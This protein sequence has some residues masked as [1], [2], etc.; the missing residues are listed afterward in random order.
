MLRA[1]IVNASNLPNIESLGKSD[2]YV[3]TVFQGVKQKTS[4]KKGDLNPE[5]DEKLEWELT[6]KPPSPD[7]KLELLVK[8][9]DTV[10]R[11]RL[12][13]K[14][15]ILLRNLMSSGQNSQEL[16]LPLVDGSDQPT[17]GVLRVRMEYTAPRTPQPAPA[18]SK[19]AANV[20][21][22]GGTKALNSYEAVQTTSSG[23][24]LL[25]QG[26][27]YSAALEGLGVGP[28]S[29][30]LL[31]NKETK[32]Q[33]RVKVVE[34]RGLIGGDL[35]PTC[36]V[37]LGNDGKSTRVQK[38]TSNPWFDEIFFYYLKK[39]PSE[40]WDTTLEFRVCNSRMLRSKV[41]L[42]VF[43]LDLGA[44]YDQPLHAFV[45]KWL[46]LT[47]LDEDSSGVMGFLKVSIA[48]MGPNDECPDLKV[49]GNTG[50]EDVESNLLFPAG[51]RLSPA[52]FELNVFQAEDLPRMDTGAMSTVKR[53]LGFGETSSK[54][55]V[56]PFL[57]FSFA[58]K[59]V[60]TTVVYKSD[61]PEFKQRLY[62]G[63]QFPAFANQLKL[64][65][66]DWDRVGDS[67]SIGTAYL[68]LAS[69]SAAGED[70]FLPTF[71]PCFVNFYGST[72]EFSVFGK[73][74]Q[75]MLDEGEGEGCAYRGRCLV[76]LRTSVG[77]YPNVASE[78]LDFEEGLK[79]D[80]YLRRR[81][82]L[83][84]CAF[85]DATMVSEVDKPVEFEVSMGNFGNK[86][87]D[88]VMP[89]PSF[90]QPTNAVFDGCQY[91]FLPWKGAK[92]CVTVHCQWE[93]ISHRLH[94]LNMLLMTAR[95]LE[96]SL[97][98]LRTSIQAGKTQEQLAIEFVGV[99]D[100]LLRNCRIP[101][102]TPELH[103][104]STNLLDNLL[105]G[106]R[107]ARLDS[108]IKGVLELKETATDLEE[109]AEQLDMY[110]ATLRD[111]A[112]EPQNSMP[113]I[114]I[115]ML[116]G[117]K[118]LAYCRIPAH[119]ILFAGDERQSGADCGRLQTIQLKF[120]GTKN[121]SCRIPALL[122]VRLWLGKEQE[123]KAW[124][125][126]HRDAETVVYAETY[127][128]QASVAGHWVTKGP[129][130]TRPKWSDAGGDM[131]LPRENFG[132]PDG[133]RFAG[134]WFVDPEPSLFYEADAGR[135]TFL[136]DVFENENRLPAGG[137]MPALTQWSDVRGDPSQ[138][139]DEIAAP[140][141]WEWND[142]WTVDLNRAVDEEGWEYCVEATLGGYGP[143]DKLYHL[144]RRRR[145][146]RPRTL[147]H[148]VAAED[149]VADKE[150]WEYAPLFGMKFHARERKVDMVRRRRWHRKLVLATEGVPKLPIFHLKDPDSEAVH[151]SCPKMYLVHTMDQ[152]YQL[153]AYIYQ[154]RDLLAG[155]KTGFSDP[156]AC[157][158]FLNV[159]QRTEQAKAT[160]CPTW[161]QTLLYDDLTIHGDPMFIL[162][163][164]PQ[165][166][167]EV[168][169][170]DAYGEPEFLG[171]AVATPTVHLDP[172]KAKPP[173]LKWYPF[174]KGDRADAG[175]LLASFELYCKTTELPFLPPTKKGGTL[176]YVPSG[177]RPVLQRTA[178]EIL[179][180]GVRNMKSF[181]LRS[182]RNP[183]IEFECAGKIVTSEVMKDVK[184]HPN[185]AEPFLFM[186]I[187]LPK[188]PLYMPPLN[189]KVRDHRSFGSRPVVGTHVVKSLHEY[190]IEPL[191]DVKSK[192]VRR[193]STVH[194][195]STVPRQSTVI[196]M[197][198]AVPEE[199]AAA[200]AG[201]APNAQLVAL[202]EPGDTELV[203]VAVESSSVSAGVSAPG[204]NA[205][206][207]R[208]ADRRSKNFDYQPL[209][210]LES[211]VTVSPTAPP[212]RGS[213]L[214]KGRAL[215]STEP[216][217]PVEAVSIRG[218]FSGRE[219]FAHKKVEKRLLAAEP[220][221]AA[222]ERTEFAQKLERHD[223]EA[224]DRAKN[225]DWWS[226]YYASAGEVRKCGDYLTK[227]YEKLEIYPVELERVACF[228]HFRDILN[229][230]PILRGKS[231]EDE[232]SA[233]VG[234]FKGTM[235]VYTLPD[236]PSVPLPPRQI[237]G[238]PPS[239]SEEVIVRVY[240]IRAWD[241]SPQDSSGF[242]DPYLQVQ[243]GKQRQTTKDNY[244]PATL[245]PIF[246]SF[247]E[248]TCTL[249]KEKDLTISVLDYDVI[250]KDD[251]IG[252][253]EIDLENRYMTKYRATCGIPREYHLSGPN[254][255]RDS[256]TPRE[257][258]ENVCETNNRSQPLW[259]SKTEVVIGNKHYRLSELEDRSAARP[260]SLGPDDERLALLVLHTF[261][262][263]PEHV[264]TR[265]L[266]NPAMPDLEQGK[267]EMMVDIFPKT[268]GPPGP[269][270]DVTPREP[271]KYQL[272]VVLYNVMDV[273]MQE[274]SAVSQ[275]N[276]SD[277][278][279]K[280]WIQ[281]DKNVQKTDVHYRCMD[282]EA[283]FNWRFVFDINY[284]E[285]ERMI[286]IKSKD[287][288]WS[289]AEREEHRP[290]KLMFQ[291]WDN[292]LISKDDYIGEIE[293]DLNRL[294]C[295]AR[296]AADCS[297]SQLDGTQPDDTANNNNGA[298]TAL[299]DSLRRR[300][301][302]EG[303]QGPVDIWTKKRVMGFWPT[304]G[305][306]DGERV[307]TGKLEMEIE[308]LTAEEAEQ[309][310]AGVARE[311]PNT[312]PT[313]PEPNRPATSFLWFSS[314]WKSFK[315]IIWKKYKWYMITLILIL[316]LA[317]FLILFLYNVPEAT[318]DKIF[319]L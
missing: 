299:T 11:N 71:G 171:R 285:A 165:V 268:A 81:K 310:P 126:G 315:H 301:K 272:R 238:I 72:R 305:E 185:F 223:P 319:G 130:M 122:R 106:Q 59:E 66:K 186:E 189:I 67:D 173:P 284:L 158:S 43:K 94:T 290:P 152:E 266:F 102:P 194:R 10:G 33:I 47:A 265:R 227:G 40:V 288:F 82:Y 182:V 296:T 220:S 230:L 156:Y 111:L 129:T 7:E 168:F 55:L 176:Y 101:L 251:L 151:L 242:S 221:L 232:E 211:Q 127:E 39:L 100:Q 253:T 51:L 25:G 147:V 224:S 133:W 61:H 31:P 293:L 264:E 135:S 23:D 260:S 150:G 103:V 2:P 219:G 20:A 300:K 247:M 282:G 202:A 37:S 109:A 209:S 74:D 29:R 289:L 204:S 108:I 237:R 56:D 178:V 302:E 1:H 115:W 105:F 83:V 113:D 307:C 3:T 231:S 134:D 142:A 215:T 207:G 70:G 177:I 121:K 167:I 87:E 256:Q 191:M 21:G 79:I 60:Q 99:C 16:E 89:S 36:R 63:F 313:L 239:A 271:S 24:I 249:P 261:D 160:L 123:S 248:F 309:R 200:A 91:Y 201:D 138:P 68:P 65:L 34:A 93:D 38:A 234:E 311:E 213:P 225:M 157:V 203:A 262:L 42:G 184:Q 280:C 22:G 112:V 277:V 206:R 269:P 170:H 254:Q 291:I 159:S 195:Q 312:N 198:P 9:H 15:T 172:S 28:R 297:L 274:Y 146:V 287:H 148:K 6:G 141:G 205:R 318:I 5:W 187:M 278:Y 199:P 255:W 119:T 316:L 246:G 245:N 181:E 62:L 229:T 117:K 97:S 163:Q 192:P 263:V 306:V 208:F 107:R 244:R 27:E 88:S 216:E 240:V 259:L 153:R 76:A 190:S 44:V 53:V 217:P 50:E 273:V 226:K 257:I 54:Q 90:T 283:M 188:E 155:D 243:L 218:N 174:T 77:E 304:A 120:P 92:P 12:L 58:G 128:N 314:P 197:E 164:P 252:E 233:T 32:F 298:L 241:L 52:A 110:A 154:A 64:V 236:D 161:D 180:W 228:G 162:E 179:C 144:C 86:F 49:T 258:L 19:S 143:V 125:E 235:R 295:P 30:D 75:D 292:D 137:W 132:A 98:F 57:I 14:T 139:R 4:V 196:D 166:V 114:I 78:P 281:G 17:T 317:L 80:S 169:D 69:I 145:W 95:T 41:V 308:V 279:V 149:N 116:S 267:L 85:E 18:G 222:Q 212:R 214:R 13:G 140:R 136:E 183:A 294:L 118:R 193:Q 303:C 8:D 210:D 46:A 124:I 73:D 35:N 175:E 275:S 84:H 250:S 131:L 26:A 48:I 96:K 276:M 270:F 104:Q 45:N 286:V